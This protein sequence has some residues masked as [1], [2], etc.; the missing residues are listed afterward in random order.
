M[1]FFTFLGFSWPVNTPLCIPGEGCG[2]ERGWGG[3]REALGGKWGCRKLWEALGWECRALELHPG[4]TIWR[5]VGVSH[6][7]P[8]SGGAIG[9]AGT[10]R[11]FGVR[12]VPA[13]HG[14][15]R[16]EGSALAIPGLMISEES[17]GLSLCRAHGP[18]RARRGKRRGSSGLLGPVSWWDFLDVGE[19]RVSSQCW[20]G[21]SIP[22]P[23]LPCLHGEE[24]AGCTRDFGAWIHTPLPGM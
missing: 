4:V 5:G 17:S 18:G 2:C 7:C 6:P 10:G 19:A 20:I 14:V 22:V 24:G 16:Q 8:G 21:A 3:Q 11:N 15:T 13:G 9:K 23:S 12:S 1:D